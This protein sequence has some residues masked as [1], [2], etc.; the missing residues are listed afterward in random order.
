MANTVFSEWTKLFTDFKPSS[1]DMNQVMALYRRN[2]ETGSA[3]IQIATESAQKIAR[4]NAELVRSNTER[5]LNASKELLNP[6]SSNQNRISRQA[7]LARNWW[8]YNINALR[9]LMELS[10][11]STQEAFDVL[12]KRFAE[13][14]DFSN[15]AQTTAENVK[16]K[17]AA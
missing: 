9:E 5:A 17:V 6:S 14:R 12:N 11:K 2:V 13:Q 16:R 7:D 15:A 4:R 8:E 10:S 3:V 1:V